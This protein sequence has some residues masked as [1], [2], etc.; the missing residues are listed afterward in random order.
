[1]CN[2]L[3]PGTHVVNVHHPSEI[4]TLLQIFNE[5]NV[6]V[7]P[8]DP[9]LRQFN[10]GFWFQRDGASKWDDGTAYNKEVWPRFPESMPELTEYSC[11]NLDLETG[12]PAIGDCALL[13]DV[14]VCERRCD[15]K[16]IELVS[17]YMR[18]KWRMVNALSNWDTIHENECSNTVVPSFI[19]DPNS[20]PEQR[21]LLNQLRSRNPKYH[22]LIS[23]RFVKKYLRSVEKIAMHCM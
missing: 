11:I 20:T 12:R 18:E 7:P 5:Y 3:C 17:F 4:E 8:A 21:S 16:V 2:W 19:G 14:V 22:L 23:L 1:M 9:E 10:L 15:F 13:Y 6:R